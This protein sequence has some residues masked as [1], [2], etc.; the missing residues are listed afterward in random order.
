MM[1]KIAKAA[2]AAP[3]RTNANTAFIS[4]LMPALVDALPSHMSA[5]RFARIAMYCTKSNPKLMECLNTDHGKS[6]LL[7]AFMQAAQLGLEPG[8]LGSCYILP[9]RNRRENATEANFQIGYRG[10]VELARRS[11]EIRTLYAHEVCENDAFD[12]SFGVGGGLSHRPCLRGERGEVIGYYAFAELADGAVQYEYWSREQIEKHRDKY[13]KGYAYD[14]TSSPW[15]TEPDEMAKKTMI[16]RLFKMLPVSVELRGVFTGAEERTLK[17]DAG[18][19]VDVTDDEP[20]IVDA[21]FVPGEDADEAQQ[22]IGE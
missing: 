6:T 10:M 17:L 12:M 22:T 8:V 21:S 4:A 16:R 20:V 5:D 7:G 9:Y 15:A 11:G 3:A 13:S 19:V 14:K 1:G 18:A 2:N